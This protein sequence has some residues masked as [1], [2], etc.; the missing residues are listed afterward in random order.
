MLEDNE[1]LP[2]KDPIILFSDLQLKALWM[3]RNPFSRE[4]LPKN[5]LVEK[6]VKMLMLW[7]TAKN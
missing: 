5:N 3:I 7:S 4:K 1:A 2:F 6:L